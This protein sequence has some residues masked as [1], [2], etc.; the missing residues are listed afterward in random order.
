MKENLSVIRTKAS[1]LLNTPT[2]RRWREFE[3]EGANWNVR[4]L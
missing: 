1:P 3:S 2:H 4:G